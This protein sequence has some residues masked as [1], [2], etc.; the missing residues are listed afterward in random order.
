MLNLDFDLHTVLGINYKARYSNGDSDISWE[1]KSKKF[2]TGVDQFL[3][4]YNG[5]RLL[6]LR[7]C[8]CLGNEYAGY[9]D[10]WIRFAIIMKTEKLDLDFSASPESQS[11]NLYDFPCQ[12][13][14]QPQVKYFSFLD[15]PRLEK[16]HIRYIAKTLY[17][18]DD[19]E[20]TPQNSDTGEEPKCLGL[21]PG[22]NEK[23]LLKNGPYGFYVQLGEDR[24]GY[25]PKRASVSQGNHP[26]DG[27]PVV[28]KL[29]KFGFSIRHRHTIV[30]VPENLKPNDITFEKA[31]ELLLAVKVVVL[32][33]LVVEVE[34][35][36]GGGGGGVV[37][38]LG[39]CNYVESSKCL[40]PKGLWLLQSTSANPEYFIITIP[41]T[42]PNAT[43]NP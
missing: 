17:G 38:T 29:E 9:V 33:V 15:V 4:L 21:Y 18:D 14:L 24:K 11:N 19:E 28:L 13:L 32:V 1:D 7:I 22:S 37:A 8:F 3:E 23:I 25:L 34:G 39:C 26:D 42:E 35:Q 41:L 5:Q 6:T 36:V 40:N 2:V 27:Q 10:R 43:L 30:P 12:L 31:L 16:V 20:V